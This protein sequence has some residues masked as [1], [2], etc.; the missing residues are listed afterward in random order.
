MFFNKGFIVSS[1]FEK[2]SFLKVITNAKMVLCVLFGIS[3]FAVHATENVIKLKPK[4]CVAVHQGQICYV[5][6][7]LDWQIE[8]AGEYCLFSSQQTQALKCWANAS[9]GRFEKEI[10]SKE[11]VTFTIKNMTSE[12]A[13]LTT[14]LKMA[15]VYKKNSRAHLSWRMF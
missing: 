15:W 6:I 9:H 11:N 13:L 5:D 8:K 7:E 10:E 3:V 12:K 14:E 4:Q 1:L 2:S